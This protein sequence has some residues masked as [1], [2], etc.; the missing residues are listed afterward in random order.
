VKTVSE[1][2]AAIESLTPSQ[3]RQLQKR[4]HT[5]GIFVA[6]ELLSDSRK[7]EV[8]VAVR[9]VTKPGARVLQAVSRPAAAQPATIPMQVEPYTP[10][11]AAR[12]ATAGKVVV[13]SPNAPSSDGL[14]QVMAPLPG[15]APE[16]PIHI[17]FDGGSRGNPGEGYGSYQLRWPGNPPQVI[18]LGFGDNMTNNEAGYDTLIAAL[19]AVLKRMIDSKSDPSGAKLEIRGDSLLVINQV[20]GEWKTK[21][22]RME[23]RRDRV[24]ALLRQFGNWTLTHHDREKSV[25]A[26][27]H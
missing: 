16:L 8:A 2:V 3:R 5:A 15:Q 10:Q 4:L 26:L 20:M 13:G 17:V 25:R 9:T 27:G 22:A 19:E 6:E 23:Q 24:R 18:R 11:M 1:I 21:D 7:L 14:A 12:P